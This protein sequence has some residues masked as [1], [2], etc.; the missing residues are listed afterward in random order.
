MAVLKHLSSKS[1]DYTKVMEYLM[2]Q[3]DER[4]Q[5][6]ILDA[7]GKKILR[8]EYYLDGLNCHPSSFDKE[9]RQLNARYHKNQKYREIKSHHYI[10]S[11]DPRDAEESGL[12]GKRAQALGLEFAQRFFPG[13]Q[14][15][16]CTHMDGHN[17][18]GNIHVHIVINSLRKLDVERQDFMERLCDS[19]AGYKHHQTRNYLTAMQRGIMEMAEREHLHQ[20]DLF[21][22]A[23]SKITE[24]EY[25]S[26]QRGQEK[27]DE[28]N[29]EIF[30]AQ[31]QPRTTVFQ[32]QKQYLRDA[33]SDISERS[34]SVEEFQKLLKEKYGIELKVHRGRFSYLHPE[35]QKYITGRALGSDFEKERLEEI[36]QMNAE[37]TCLPEQDTP[38]SDTSAS[39]EKSVAGTPTGIDD[40]K[41]DRNAY[42]HGYDYHADPIAILYVR[43]NLR[44]VTDLQ[45]NIKAQQSAAYARKVKLSNLKEMARTVVYIQEHGY[46][47]AEDLQQHQRQISEKRA[48]VQMK[49]AQTDEK[50]RKVNEQIHFAGQYYAT[51]QIQKDFLNTR[52]KKRFRAEHS[53]ELDQYNEAVAYFL[54]NCGGS[55]PS[56]KQLKAEKAD[57]KGLQDEQ[58][59]EFAGLDRWSKELEIAAQNV[60]TIL[61]SGPSVGRGKRRNQ[62]EL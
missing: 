6:P 51:R 60:D 4:T 3:H 13:H 8:E 34:A 30:A 61:H 36:F 26:K 48:S 29:A 5:K 62:P 49:L 11:F 25:R 56:M 12:T 39:H 2:F 37:H 59:K 27:L 31:M 52:F 50:Y 58:R 18:S 9:C 7:N 20:I 40:T 44:L 16:V 14:A 35:R 23:K 1:A 15:L 33:I 19:R 43:S 24:K 46:D 17:G 42:T 10:L 53:A 38:K 22:P 32:T 41:E 55:I 21:T 54:G 57:L 45:A 28:L 47:T